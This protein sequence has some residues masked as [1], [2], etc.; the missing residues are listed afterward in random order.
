[1]HTATGLAHCADPKLIARLDRAQLD[2]RAFAEIGWLGRLVQRI[3]DVVQAGSAGLWKQLRKHAQRR[4][5]LQLSDAQL[6][7]TGIDPAMAGR[8][9][10]AEVR[11]EAVRYLDSLAAQ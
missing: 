4:Q 8:G 2:P 11:A 3:G 5:L 1:M 10:A 7:D 9:R 6:R